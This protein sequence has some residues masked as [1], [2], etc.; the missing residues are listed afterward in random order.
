MLARFG[1]NVRTRRKAAGWTQ[2][3]FGEK[4]DLHRTYVADVEMGFRNISLLNVVKIAG[5]LGISVS[6]L[7]R[8]MGPREC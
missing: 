1:E 7:C 8:G 5:A 3:E 2:E 6:E 4:A